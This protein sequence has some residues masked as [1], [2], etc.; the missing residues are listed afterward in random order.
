M[1]KNKTAVDLDELEKAIKFFGDYNYENA[2]YLILLRD[3][4]RA[5]LSEKR[6]EPTD[7]IDW[8]NKHQS[9]A[10]QRARDYQTFKPTG[11]KRAEAIEYL[12]L[13]KDRI[14]IHG[15]WGMCE[16]EG[17]NSILSVLQENTAPDD[18]VKALE[19]I[20]ELELKY[21]DEYEYYY[22]DGE[23]VEIAKGA[24]AAHKQKT[25]GGV[26]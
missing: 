25:Q 18:L 5:Y 8:K 24:L 22:V 23:A 3:A 10:I 17:Y 14:F 16:E 13:F 1:A 21:D 11:D 15:S 19:K 4:S 20:S 2:H 6:S 12:H 7:G 9:E 26:E